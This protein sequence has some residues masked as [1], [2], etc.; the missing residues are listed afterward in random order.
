M[1]TLTLPELAERVVE[2]LPRLLP[3]E[4]ACGL[5]EVLLPNGRSI[6]AE[7]FTRNIITPN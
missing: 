6:L 7:I 2:V 3:A 5:V 1:I 4:P